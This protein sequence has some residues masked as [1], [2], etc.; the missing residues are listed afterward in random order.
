[1]LYLEGNMI[2]QFLIMAAIGLSAWVITVVI[3][4]PDIIKKII[5][6]VAVIFVLVLALQALGVNVGSHGTI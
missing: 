6:A 4:M 1:M 2:R 5:I 3:P